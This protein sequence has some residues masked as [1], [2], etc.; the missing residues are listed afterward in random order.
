MNL[1]FTSE[2]TCTSIISSGLVQPGRP[3]DKKSVLQHRR[4]KNNQQQEKSGDSKQKSNHYTECKEG[5]QDRKK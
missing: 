3:G 1:K 2:Q 4:G 5:E